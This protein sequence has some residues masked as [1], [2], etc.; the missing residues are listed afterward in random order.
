MEKYT[1]FNDV[2][3]DRIYFAED[4]LRM[5]FGSCVLFDLQHSRDL[6]LRRRPKKEFESWLPPFLLL[7][8]SVFKWNL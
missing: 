8:R 5:R 3:D 1:F 6:K 7:V 4:F 2:D